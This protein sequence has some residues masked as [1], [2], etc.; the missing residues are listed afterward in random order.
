MAQPQH[1]L[2]VIISV[3]TYSNMCFYCVIAGIQPPRASPATVCQCLTLWHVNTS[4]TRGMTRVYCVRFIAQQESDCVVK[5]CSIF[6]FVVVKWG[7]DICDPSLALHMETLAVVYVG[8]M[9]KEEAE[10][11]E[12]EMKILLKINFYLNRLIKYLF[13]HNLRL[14]QLLCV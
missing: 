10:Q 3:S 8:H 4:C 14:H 5:H 6:I 13:V 2:N 1:Q 7:R 9:T 12:I 11:L